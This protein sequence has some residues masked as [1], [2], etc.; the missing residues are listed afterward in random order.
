M[1]IIGEHTHN[2]SALMIQLGMHIDHLING[3]PINGR[4]YNHI[5]IEHDGYVYEAIGHGVVKW[6]L[7]EHNAQRKVKNHCK[8]IEFNLDLTKIE[9][10]KALSYL[11]NQKGKKYEY[12]NF[13]WHLKKIFTNKW[14]GDKTD[15]KLYCTELVIRAMNF[16]GKYN[17]DPYL[18]PIEI[19]ELLRIII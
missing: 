5:L 16:T 14:K 10:H 2:F 3:N 6:T 12:A 13:Y 19:R 11:E 18:N 17:I 1:K 9:L 8:R 7:A 4:V 15:K